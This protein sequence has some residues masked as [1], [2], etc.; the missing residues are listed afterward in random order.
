MGRLTAV[1][2]RAPRK[3][4]D[5]IAPLIAIVQP[6][7]SSWAVILRILCMPIGMPDVTDAEKVCKTMSTKLKTRALAFIGEDTSFAMGYML[8]QH[9]K[10]VGTKDWESQTDSADEEF[11]ALGIYLPACYPRQE[12]KTTWLCA[13]ESSIDRIQRADVVDLGEV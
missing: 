8:Y 12:G 10:K 4:D 6:K 2:V 11:A 7:E 5:E 1:P 13:H 9:G 3:K